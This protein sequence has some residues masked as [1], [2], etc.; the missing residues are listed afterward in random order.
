MV[1]GD[2]VDPAELTKA[3]ADPGAAA[4]LI[5]FARIRAAVDGDQIR[6]STGFYRST[7]MAL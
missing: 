4:L 2:P 6:P 3:L 7:R 1:D 5:D